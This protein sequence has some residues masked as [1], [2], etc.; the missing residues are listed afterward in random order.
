M[1]AAKSCVK[2][3][4][5]KTAQLGTNPT[6]LGADVPI[7]IFEEESFVREVAKKACEIGHLQKTAP[8]E[9]SLRRPLMAFT[10]LSVATE[11]KNEEGR[12]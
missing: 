11:E 6:Q 3:G 5:Y 10:E 7:A 1:A 9:N 8:L 2:S 4:T 12:P